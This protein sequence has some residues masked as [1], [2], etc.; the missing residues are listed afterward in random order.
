ME[1]TKYNKSDLA[2][3]KIL[4]LDDLAFLTGKSKKTLYRKMDEIPHYIGGNGYAFLWDEIEAWLCQVKCEP[5]TI[6]P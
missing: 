4:N 6:T 3:K 2:A 5:T 1:R